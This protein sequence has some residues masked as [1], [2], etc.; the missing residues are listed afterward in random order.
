MLNKLFTRLLVTRNSSPCIF[1][2]NVVSLQRI[3]NVEG[4]VTACNHNKKLL[5]GNLSLH[6]WYIDISDFFILNNVIL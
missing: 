3:R 1:H 4:F 5:K 6:F 2:N